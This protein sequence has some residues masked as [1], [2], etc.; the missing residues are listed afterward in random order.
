M[1]INEE[2]RSLQV[3][4]PEYGIIPILDA[5]K[6]ARELNVDLLE[7]V[8]DANPPVCKLM[9]YSKYKFQQKKKLTHQKVSKLKEL[10]FHVNTQPHDITYKLNHAKR[11]ISSGDKVKITIQFRGREMAHIEQGHQLM[12]LIVDQLQDVAKSES[13]SKLEGNLLQNIF[14]KI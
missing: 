7:I 4:I 11:F 10:K 3:R 9:E 8:P 13:T 6:K 2:I 14:V 1:R 5:L 12:R